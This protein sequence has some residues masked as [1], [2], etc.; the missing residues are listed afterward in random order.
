M[1]FASDKQ[2]RAVHANINNR[3]LNATGGKKHTHTEPVFFADTYPDAVKYAKEKHKEDPKYSM[4]PGTIH[5]AK[6]QDH[7]TGMIA[8][9]GYRMKPMSKREL[10]YR[11][12]SPE[13]KRGID[14][15]SGMSS[16]EMSET[17]KEYEKQTGRRA[18]HILNKED[19]YSWID[20]TYKT[21]PKKKN[22][23]QSETVLKEKLDKRYKEYVNLF[24]TG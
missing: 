17:M 23:S 19:V 8:W 21:K 20:A 10:E 14:K 11:E 18:G 16:S 4:L 2:R 1:K 15:F 13:A 7:N 24:E 12:F 22:L 6:D 5:K 9:T 3:N